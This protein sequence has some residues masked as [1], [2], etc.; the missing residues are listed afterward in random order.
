MRRVRYIRAWVGPGHAQQRST[1]PQ[2]GLSTVG[3]ASPSAGWGLSAAF[4]APQ[5]LLAWLAL[6]PSPLCPSRCLHCANPGRD[7]LKGG[8]PELV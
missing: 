3:K 4:G 1:Q 2:P 8:P 6:A 5:D 7:M